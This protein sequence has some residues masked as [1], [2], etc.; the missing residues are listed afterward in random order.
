MQLRP[1][2]Q[3]IEQAAKVIYASDEGCWS[4]VDS[5]SHA[6]AWSRVIESRKERYRCF[7]R[8]AA[9]W[10]QMSWNGPT[11]EEIASIHGYIERSIKGGVGLAVVGT[12][13]SKF[14]EMR[15]TDIFPANPVDPRIAWI[16]SILSDPRNLARE[17]TTENIAEQIVQAIDSQDSMDRLRSGMTTIDEERATLKKQGRI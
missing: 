4:V 1:T 15:N 9:L 13:I 17:I 7:A 2:D 14:V 10:V 16:K 5:P 6:L 3:Q 12:A 11:M 8:A